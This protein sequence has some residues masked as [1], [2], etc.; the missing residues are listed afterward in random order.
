MV[1][2][3]AI[4]VLLII[5][6]ILNHLSKIVYYLMQIFSG[7]LANH[8]E[9]PDGFSFDVHSDSPPVQVDISN[10]SRPED[11]I[12]SHDLFIYYKSL[13]YINRMILGFSIIM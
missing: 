4:G 6:A 10:S 5:S 13:N 12:S 8:Y 1:F 11:F 7:V 2:I 9:P 3:E